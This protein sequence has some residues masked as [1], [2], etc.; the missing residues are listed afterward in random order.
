MKQI[1][2]SRLSKV[3]IR[4]I[5]IV[6]FV[7]QICVTVGLVGYFSFRNGQRTVNDLVIKL[8]NEVNSKVFLHLDSYLKDPVK[9]NQ[10]NADLIKSGVLDYQNSDKLEKYFYAQIKN[11]NISY[12]NFG[13]AQGKFTGILKEKKDKNLVNFNLEVFNAASDKKMYVY[14]LK[15]DGSRD[16][17]LEVRDINPL[18]DPWYT[19]AVKAGKPIWSQIYQWQNLGIISISYSYPVYNQQNRLVGVLGTDLKLSSIG[20]FL[21]NINISPNGRVFI[22]ERN[23]F[24]VA[25]SNIQPPFKYEKGKI[26]RLKAEESDDDLIKATAQYLKA[27]FDFYN[28]K[29][30]EHLQFVVNRE[31]IFVKVAPW[32]DKFGLNWLVVES[33]PAADFMGQIY[34][35]NRNTLILSLLALL[36]SIGVGIL[37]ARWI[38]KPIIK[39]KD[40]ATAFANGEFGQTIPT[41][42]KDE[43]GILTIAFN[44]MAGQLQNAFATLQKTNLLLE[45]RVEERTAEL[46]EAKEMADAANAAKSDFLA[47]MSHELRTPLNGILGYAQILQRD[48]K[49][50][51][52]QL[53]AFNIIYQCGSHLLTLIND[54][55]DL[56]KIEARKLEL[57]NQDFQ[58]NSF[59][60]SIVEICRIRAEQKDI[61]FSYE[62]VNKLPQ[63]IHTD[64]KRLRQV[65][66]NLLGNAIKFTDRGSVL[67]RISVINESIQGKYCLR[68]EVTDTGVGMTPEQLDKIFIPFEQVG[69][70]QRMAEGTGLGLAISQQIVELMGSQ[71][72]VKSTLGE[73]STFWFDVDVVTAAEWR[74]IQ[75]QTSTENIIGYEGKRRQILI[76]DDRWE[77]RSVISHLL[78]LLDFELIEA[79]NGAEGLDKAMIHKPDCIITDLLMPVMDGLE[80]VAKLRSLPQFQHT[81]IIAA[82]ASVFDFNRQ[83]SQTAGCNGFLPKPIQSDELLSQLSVHLGLTWI[84]EAETVPSVVNDTA[85][86][87][88]ALVLPD[89]QELENLQLA[90][91]MGDIDTLEQAAQ[92]LIQLDRRYEPFAAQLLQLL[93]EM[94]ESAIV[95]FIQQAIAEVKS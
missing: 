53:D 43:L 73:G 66:I 13:H 60:N 87:A 6:P 90:A 33:V 74:E 75:P 92:H 83:Q 80:M 71:I 29:G 67:L 55:L 88:I 84:R 20:N 24:L 2:K 39:L 56:S 52:K 68:F 76:V 8:Q 15:P 77:N 34:E 27:N 49:S 48:K 25:N 4:T 38:T 86:Q 50:T 11:S 26:L 40:A 10:I 95:K 57:V 18:L 72:Q 91:R 94:N 17:I 54:I 45:Q 28:I 41:Q 3:P 21:K 93:Q 1:I 59:L 44:S 79:S 81:I 30:E 23:G 69:D 78:G 42:R 16:N 19:D 32:K 61:E 46:K 51:A 31:I 85:N 14:N 5:L 82:S 64:E 62:A 22:L 9:L 58:F 70:R 65:L 89:I 35:N 7:I 63:F 12:I 37:T 47:N 36:I